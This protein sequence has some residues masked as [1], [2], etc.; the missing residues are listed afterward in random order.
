MNIS[1]LVPLGKG[2]ERQVEARGYGTA[3]EFVRDLLRRE[4]EQAARAAI[5]ARLLQAIESGEA[6]PMSATDWKRIRNEGLKLARKRG[7]K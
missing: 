7:K 4:Q 1:L 6:T 2:V 5:D 3:S